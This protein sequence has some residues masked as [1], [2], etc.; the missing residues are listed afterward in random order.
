MAPRKKLKYVDDPVRLGQRLRAAREA[1]SLSQRDLSM[2]GCTPAYI[3]RIEK[4]ERIPSLQV[5]RELAARTGVSEQ[6]LAYGKR[7]APPEA[8][9]LLAEARAALRL[10]DTDVALRIAD[11]M[12]DGA[13]SAR[14]R[15][16]ATALYGELALVR[17]DAG[18][19]IEAIERARSIDPTLLDDD[20]AVVEALGHAYARAA[21]HEA[22]AAVFGAARDRAVAAGDDVDTVRFASQLASTHIDAAN[23]PAAEEALAGL[24]EA[25]DELFDPAARAK[26]LWAQS[27]RHAKRN[28][29]TAALRDAERALA[30]LEVSDQAYHAALCHQLLAHIEGERGHSERAIE[31]LERAAP[32]IAVAGRRFELATFR[33]EFARALLGV[34]RREEAVV[35][36]EDAAGELTSLSPVEAGR[37][38]SLV[39][40]VFASLGDTARAIELYEAG[41]AY[42]QETPNRY[43]VEACT[44]LGELLERRGEHAAAMEIY[45]QGMKAQL[46]ADRA[47]DDRG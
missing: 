31:L 10:E 13:R 3:S 46:R 45:K 14:D 40:G 16:T 8:S 25:G 6:Y 47:V 12:S 43:L 38:Y 5:L 33:V 21:D 37:A 15:A 19:A 34:G 26:L 9:G 44:S 20:A 35:A 39:A 11:A 30:V 4:G 32:L 2:P 28:E 1:A 42:L 41:I 7:G 18:A 29:R 24:V 27:R 22:A 36:A 17:G 23:L